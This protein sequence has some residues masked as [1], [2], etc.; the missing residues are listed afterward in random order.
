MPWSMSLLKLTQREGSTAPGAESDTQYRVVYRREGGVCRDGDEPATD[1][2]DRRLIQLRRRT[3]PTQIPSHTPVSL[4]SSIDAVNGG[5]NVKKVKVA[6][7]RLPSVGF[8][9]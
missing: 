4:Q 1:V 6:H 2:H 3:R 8:Q 5:N 9:S 7:T